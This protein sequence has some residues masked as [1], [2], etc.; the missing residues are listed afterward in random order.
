MKKY[1]YTV[2]SYSREGLR[3][4]STDASVLQRAKAEITKLAPKCSCLSASLIK[5][6]DPSYKLPNGDYYYDSFSKLDGKDQE[7]GWW[8]IKDLLSNGWE[9]FDSRGSVISPAQS[10]YNRLEQLS[11][12]I[13]YDTETPNT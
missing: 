6:N 13:E 10:D 12:R 4:E 1:G 8:L 7:L 3:I 9:P 5:M 11:L 2:V